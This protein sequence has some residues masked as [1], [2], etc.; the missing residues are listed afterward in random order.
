MADTISKMSINHNNGINVTHMADKDCV[1][2]SVT[3]FALILECIF[4][5]FNLYVYMYICIDKK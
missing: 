5:C 3:A 4:I 1:S 2:I